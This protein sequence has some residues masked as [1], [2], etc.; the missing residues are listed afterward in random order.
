MKSTEAIQ[1]GLYF[2]CPHNGCKQTQPFKRIVAH[3]TC[4]HHWPHKNIDAWAAKLTLKDGLKE[5]DQSDCK[6]SSDR[7]HERRRAPPPAKEKADENMKAGGVLRIIPTP[8]EGFTLGAI[9]R[10]VKIA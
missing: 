4:Q 10:I 1:S 6:P 2:R 7:P 5:Q 8:D 3:I 9:A